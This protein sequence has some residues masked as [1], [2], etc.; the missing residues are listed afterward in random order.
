MA[1]IFV[2]AS[3]SAEK[4]KL[5][6]CRILLIIKIRSVVS[7]KNSLMCQINDGWATDEHRV[8]TILIAYES[9]NL[10]DALKQLDVNIYEIMTLTGHHT[11]IVNCLLVTV[12]NV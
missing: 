1:A 4:Q 6:G 10:V 3:R 9:S 11:L 12:Y 8:S 5:R 7:V 2:D